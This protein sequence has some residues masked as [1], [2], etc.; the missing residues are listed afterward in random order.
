MS[1]DADGNDSATLNDEFITYRHVGDA[2]LNLTGW[3]VHDQA[4]TTYTFPDGFTL[5]PNATVTLYTGSGTDTAT[6]LYW[7]QANEVWNDGAD[8]MTVR[9]ASGEI[10]LQRSYP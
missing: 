8:M 10:V 4:G 3:T 6:A 9:N 1:A 2:P 5:A 7:G